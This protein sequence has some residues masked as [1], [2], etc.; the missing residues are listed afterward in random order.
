MSEPLKL[1]LGLQTADVATDPESSL[2]SLLHL[3]GQERGSFRN[4]TEESLLEELE[5]P[6]NATSITTSAANLPL[7]KTLENQD[8]SLT[9]DKSPAE[10]REEMLHRISVAL[11]ESALAL[12]FTSLLL[13]GSRPSAVQSISPALK[14]AIPVGSLSHTIVASDLA[15]STEPHSIA[16]AF[17]DQSLE[18]AAAALEQFNHRVIEE[19]DDVFWSETQALMSAGWPVFRPKSET[20]GLAVRFGSGPNHYLH[21]E[22]GKDGHIDDSKLSNVKSTLVFSL[23][24]GT[25]LL[26]RQEDTDVSTAEERRAPRIVQK[27]NRARRTLRARGLFNNLVKEARELSNLRT[28]IEDLCVKAPIDRE[29]DLHIELEETSSPESTF[30][31]VEDVEMSGTE[32][33]SDHEIPS[34]IEPRKTPS[35]FLTSDDDVEMSK[36][37]TVPGF[38]KHELLFAAFRALVHLKPS[39]STLRSPIKQFLTWYHHGRELSRIQ[40]PILSLI[41]GLARYDWQGRTPTVTITNPPNPPHHSPTQSTIIIIQFLSSAFLLTI[42]SEAPLVTKFT[43]VATV[44]SPITLTSSTS[45]SVSYT[46]KHAM[47]FIQ[48]TIFETVMKEMS[49]QNPSILRISEDEVR[50]PS[51][52]DVIVKMSRGGVIQMFREDGMQRTLERDLCAEICEQWE[53]RMVP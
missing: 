36:K 14:E 20:A 10:V 11:N 44:T 23:R 39:Q 50:V 43:T 38:S 28:E 34:N 30:E 18:Y 47:T 25:E 45:T 16:L 7:T 21:L 46:A 48:Y 6:E 8:E 22:K 3:I 51:G 52:S 40:Y 1:S 33:P 19:T 17:Q 5:H 13:S 49:A 32:I 4:F 37:E 41:T 24:R 35:S 12:D 31:D 29:L 2:A 42:T 53:W 27:V 26:V 15:S 9:D